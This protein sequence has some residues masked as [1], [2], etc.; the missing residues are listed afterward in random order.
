MTDNDNFL[1]F[2]FIGLMLL[3]AGGAYRP[4]AKHFPENRML[5]VGVTLM[6]VGLGLLG[7]VAWWVFRDPAAGGT[8]ALRTVF[9][10]AAAVA[11]AGFACV[12]PSVSALISK[13]A[14]PTRQGEVLGVNQSFASLGRIIGPFMGSFLFGLHPSHSLPFAA[15]VVV[16]AAVSMLLPR[17]AGAGATR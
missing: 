6:I 14:D 7:G 10:V 11:V 3:I 13:R 15:A 12:N 5:A 16:L 9:Y 1:V 17:I 4:L 2:A 8:A